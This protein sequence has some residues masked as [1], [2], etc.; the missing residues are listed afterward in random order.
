MSSTFSIS[1]KC[2]VVAKKSLLFA[3]PFG[4]MAYMCGVL[5]IDRRKRVEAREYLAEAVKWCKENETSLV[6]FPEGTRHHDSKV[7]D[8]LPFKLGAFTSAIQAQIP[9]LPV[10]FSHYDFYDSK[11]KS[12]WKVLNSIQ[13]Y[14]LSI[15]KHL[16]L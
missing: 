15:S 10:V 2:T 16:R 11:G 7:L 8:M 6:L 1:G 3:G 13:L 9:I 4:I 12:T 5:F 14:A